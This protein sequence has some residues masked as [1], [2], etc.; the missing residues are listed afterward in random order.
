VQAAQSF[1]HSAKEVFEEVD[2]A[3]GGALDSIGTEAEHIIEH[4]LKWLHYKL[5]HVGMAIE[6]SEKE[7]FRAEQQMEDVLN[8]LILN[9]PQI[10]SSFANAA[11]NIER[12]LPEDLRK[13]LEQ[14]ADDQKKAIPSGY[15][16][17]D[18]P[19]LVTTNPDITHKGVQASANGAAWNPAEQE[20]CTFYAA[21]RRTQLG[22]PL[23][24]NDETGRWG[25]AGNWSNK[26]RN[27]NL[28]VTNTPH[29]GD[30]FC[31]RGSYGHVGIVERVSES[32][33]ILISEG[34]YGYDG[35]FNTRVVE[36]E[37]YANWDF[38]Q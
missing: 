20:Q 19:E 12:D 27:L 16:D 6:E 36:P 2:S 34:N 37:E 21:A 32:G 10:R 8:T 30:I 13:K 11:D 7:L 26:A 35:R 9:S 38:I 33:A 14:E 17:L 24:T 15:Q 3:L 22:N 18:V 5:D 1:V 31:V 25:A 4:P 28:Q 29:D 23:P